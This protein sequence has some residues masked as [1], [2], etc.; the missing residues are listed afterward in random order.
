MKTRVPLTHWAILL[1]FCAG[2]LG[3]AKARAD[4]SLLPP[5]IVNGKVPE[6]TFVDWITM[7][8]GPIT[9]TP[10]LGPAL[11]GTSFNP[12]S[13]SAKASPSAGINQNGAGG[14]EGSAT[15]SSINLTVPNWKDTEPFKTVYFEV[16][17]TSAS[18]TAGNMVLPKITNNNPVPP[19]NTSVSAPV[20]AAMMANVPIG[21][22]NYELIE[23]TWVYKPNPPFEEFTLVV[24]TT[25]VV[26]E[27][28]VATV[29]APEP[30]SILLLTTAGALCS[31]LYAWRRRKPTA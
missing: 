30:S 11:P 24:P 26:H 1:V 4:S 31:L 2:L 12:N 14:W 13:I 9:A 19:G 6:G 29:S 28:A 16:S 5:N 27:L 7:G 20:V 8:V 25:E 23:W 21:G 18:W 10:V 3:P 15:N 17:I 22:V